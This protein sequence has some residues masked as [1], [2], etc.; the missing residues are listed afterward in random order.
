MS[1][2]DR[3]GH[4]WGQEPEAPLDLTQFDDP[5]AERISWDPLQY[6]GSS[7]RTHRLERTGMYLLRIAPT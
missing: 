7:F 2:L 5:L 6:G 3:I 1:L 4:M